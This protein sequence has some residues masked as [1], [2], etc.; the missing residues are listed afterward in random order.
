MLSYR[1][2]QLF[3]QRNNSVDVP[4][5][6]CKFRHRISIL[7]CKLFRFAKLSWVA[8][9]LYRY[10]VQNQLTHHL[11]P[12]SLSVEPSVRCTARAIMQHNLQTQF[13]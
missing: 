1:R 5:P 12:P 11:P 6:L 9:R 4:L 13:Y 10:C 7:V 2:L 8:L 3:N